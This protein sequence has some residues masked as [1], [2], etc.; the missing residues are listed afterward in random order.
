MAKKD[1]TNNRLN[2][3]ASAVAAA[4][5]DGIG[6][7]QIAAALDPAIPRRPLQHLLTKLVA[8]GRLAKEGETRWT[9][10]RSGPKAML[11]FSPRS[12]KARSTQ[13]YVNLP[14]GGRRPVGYR[15]EFLDNYRPNETGYLTEA[16]RAHLRKIGTPN[17]G[18]QG[19]GAFARRI[20][21]GLLVDLAW[22]SS[23]L[24][25]NT[26]S[27]ADTRR[28]F[29]FGARAKGKTLLETLMIL[30]HKTAIE[31]LVGRAEEI[32]FD[33][34]TIMNA[35]TLLSS[36]LLGGIAD[37]GRIRTVRVGIGQSAY[38]P[39]EPRQIKECL[40]TILRKAEEIDDP[41]EQSLFAMVQLPYLQ[42]FIDVNKR[43]SRLAANIP[44]IRDN[45][46]P[47]TFAGVDDKAYK[48]AI[49]GVYEANETALL[50]ELFVWAYE[51]SAARHIGGRQGPADHGPLR[52]KRHQELIELASEVVRK[53]M[54][55][56]T[57]VRHI[58]AWTKANFRGHGRKRFREL[59]ETELLEL[60][61]GN[62]SK[63]RIT[64]PEFRAWE[65]A[66]AIKPEP[67]LF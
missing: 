36:N 66:W 9:K 32:R 7:N 10:Y 12:H 22:N 34:I 57:A 21:G 19:P 40:E 25:G 11:P 64:L 63:L 6:L 43:T 48:E 46:A 53:A 47:L 55:R 26:Y 14:L 17:A 33:R 31:F 67:R 13:S 16:E 18:T 35:H 3:I 52:A 44:L 51:Q 30:N 20:L 8:Q 49:L 38:N 24:E 15:R 62:Y 29:E 37:E 42:S 61:E 60:H 54:D 58:E 59:A 23:R 39:P 50:K 65:K 1:T 5:P 45:L 56:Q 4:H 41:F 27:A 28:L 2:A